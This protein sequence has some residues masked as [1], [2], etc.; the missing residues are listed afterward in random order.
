MRL[1]LLV[2]LLYYRVM[3]KYKHFEFHIRGIPA[4]PSCFMLKSG[5]RYDIEV[6]LFL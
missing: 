3:Y 4:F 5:L 6:F 2:K 1:I